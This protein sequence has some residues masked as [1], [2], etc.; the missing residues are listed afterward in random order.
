MKRGRHL[1]SVGLF[2]AAFSS[3]CSAPVAAQA[4][5]LWVGGGLT[6]TISQPG[7]DRA[8]GPAVLGAAEFGSTSHRLHFRAE[9]GFATQNMDTRPGGL[10][11][12]DVQTVHGALASRLSLPAFSTSLTPYVLAG[13]GAFRHSTRFVLRS[14]DNQVPDGQFSLTTS[15]VVG[16][17]FLGAG[18][19]WRL[20][21]I[22]GFAEARWMASRSSD[23]STMSVPIMLGA[24]LPISK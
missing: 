16:G 19:T 24:T 12:G 22:G 2:A 6:Q 1:F 4:V 9:A 17:G 18:I 23:G 14:S 10:A 15:E 8:P 7:S 20:A 3:I 21:G 11:T 5:D 13:V